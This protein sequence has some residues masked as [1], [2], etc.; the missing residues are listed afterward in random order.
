MPD[1][2]NP[3]KLRA[4]EQ[5]TP[6]ETFLRLFGDGALDPLIEI[7]WNTV[8]IFR[9][10]PGGGKTS[11]LRAFT[12]SALVTLYRFRPNE[13]YSDLYMK[14]KALGVMGE[15][16]PNLLSMMISCA[17]N[18]AILEDLDIDPAKKER[19]LYSLL[20]VRIILSAL[21]GALIL[22]SL[23]YPEGLKS[24]Q[25]Q[26]VNFGSFPEWLS[27]PLPC[28]GNILDDWAQKLEKRICDA[29]D[30]F[31]LTPQV[32]LI[33]HDTL[34][35]LQLLHPDA[36]T[37]Q[38]IP[39]AKR[40]L[41]MFDDV[42]K[43]T[44]RQR[45]KVI[46]TVFSTRWPVSVWLAERLEALSPNELLSPG[47][48]V[49]R[50][51]ET[52][53][54]AEY[55]GRD[56]KRKKRFEHTVLN[57]ANKRTELARDIKDVPLDGALQSSLNTTEYEPKY[58]VA[59]QVISQRIIKK[60]ASDDRYKSLLETYVDISESMRDQAISWRTLEIVLERKS[61]QIQLSLPIP[62]T[63]D[64]LERDSSS[65]QGVA[66]FFLMEEFNIPYYYGVS[67]LA[68][69]ATS[70]I[71]QFLDFAG[72]LFEQIISAALINKPTTISPH[73]QEEVLSKTI[74]RRWEEIPMRI[75]D[76][77]DVHRLLGAIKEY[78]RTETYRPT[79]PYN[80]G[81][82][83]IGLTLENRKKLTDRS[84]YMTHPEYVYLGKLL[85]NCIA[86]N[87]LEPR[88]ITHGKPPQTILVLYLNR[89]LCM[90][91]G[92]PLNYGGWRKI[93]LDRLLRWLHNGFESPDNKGRLL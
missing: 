30:S 86:Y 83:G 39:I 73:V 87:L 71:E 40:S 27:P 21:R 70:N 1:P 63:S 14:M 6:D 79:A 26:S 25:I 66:E 77:H 24:I 11:L 55:W 54:L 52:L 59:C 34:Y 17:S 65:V 18:Y 36:I 38:G 75:P 56:N 69:L 92:L 48:G 50:E 3:F 51:Y 93:G 61:N 72:D 44:E 81:V 4:A 53:A 20:N 60:F 35:S 46:D 28:S 76:G 85:S 31:D 2:R 68:E 41:V 89:W 5:I 74:R 88:L 42:H 62:L 91:A 23:P 16:G 32:D 82:T 22:K 8:Q 64:E 43:L 49:G 13:K 80:P 78:S 47:A 10:A 29:I 58:K 9:S 7:N 90:Q 19:V 57:I 67:N 37:Y 33:G 84:G 12:P 15:D 45:R